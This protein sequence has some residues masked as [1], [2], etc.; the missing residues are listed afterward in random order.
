MEGENAYSDIEKLREVVLMEQFRDCLDPDLTI[1][2]IDQNPNTLTEAARLADQYAAIRKHP[3]DNAQ[4]SY[5]KST[6]F[7]NIATIQNDQSKQTG[8]EHKPNESSVTTDSVMN[9]SENSAKTPS[10]QFRKR[11]PPRD[12]ISPN[13]T[14][15]YCKKQGHVISSCRKLLAKK[16]AENSEN[17]VSSMLVHL[18]IENECVDN[19]DIDPGYKAHCV[20]ATLTRPDQATKSI[21]LL[22]DTGTLQ[23]LLSK[24]ALSNT[25]YVNTGEHRIIKGVSGE[26]QPVPLVE[27][28]MA[29]EFASGKYLFGVANELPK[30]IDGLIGNDLCPQQHATDVL[31]VTRSQTATT[32]AASAAIPTT[33]VPSNAAVSAT[34]NTVADDDELNLADLFDNMHIIDS[35]ELIRLQRRDPTLTNLYDLVVED[36]HDKPDNSYYFLDNGVLMRSWRNRTSL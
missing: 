9:T 31:V 19:R 29:C 3:K 2:L 30:G 10:L 14:C 4:Y 6:T 34:E 24:Q 5:N 35:N 12:K 1:W 13:I 22:R 26:V 32:R 17:G 27:A 8:N 11:G 36:E 23:S 18:P 7:S 20:T 21:I 16:A 28:D 15:H 33:N 25:D